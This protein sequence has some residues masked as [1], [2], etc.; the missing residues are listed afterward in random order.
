MYAKNGRG[1]KR[2][3]PKFD[4]FPVLSA[5]Q[6]NN[7]DIVARTQKAQDHSTYFNHWIEVLSLAGVRDINQ[8]FA[9]SSGTMTLGDMILNLRARDDKTLFRALLLDGST[10]LAVYD[11]QVAV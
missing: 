3:G 11:T 4:V 10:T 6:L 5:K 1:R 8:E 2:F 9:T 7:P